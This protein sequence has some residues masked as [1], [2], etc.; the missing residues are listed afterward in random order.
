MYSRGMWIYRIVYFRGRWRYWIMYFK[1]YSMG[2]GIIMLSKMYPKVTGILTPSTPTVLLGESH[3]LAQIPKALKKSRLETK[4]H[5][6][7][8]GEIC[9]LRLLSHRLFLQ[10]PRKRK[11]TTGKGK[12]T[13]GKGKRKRNGLCLCYGAYGSKLPPAPCQPNSSCIS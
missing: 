4:K 8:L 12:E 11:R 1:M 5:S 10:S 3:P 9:S 2:M 7:F 6:F 13:C